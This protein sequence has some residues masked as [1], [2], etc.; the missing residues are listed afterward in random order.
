VKVDVRAII[1]VP[2]KIVAGICFPDIEVENAYPHM[3]L[4]VRFA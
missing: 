3:T 4:M 2:E 1:Y